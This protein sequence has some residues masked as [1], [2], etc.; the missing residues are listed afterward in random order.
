MSLSE[1]V[2]CLLKICRLAFI[3]KQIWQANRSMIYIHMLSK[4]CRIMGHSSWKKKNLKCFC[5]SLQKHLGASKRL[6]FQVFLLK[7]SV[8]C[9][10]LECFASSTSSVRKSKL[11]VPGHSTKKGKTTHTY[12]RKDCTTSYWH[13][14]Y[15]PNFVYG[16]LRLTNNVQ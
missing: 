2:K 5:I 14:Q 6:L 8:L 12:V 16:I 11:W 15:E 9:L 10:I 13:E 7:L 1:G 3:F 4:I